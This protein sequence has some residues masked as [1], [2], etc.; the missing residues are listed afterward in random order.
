MNVQMKRYDILSEFGAVYDFLDRQYDPVHL[1]GYLLPEFWE[2]AHYHNYFDYHHS[3]RMGI[4]R[5]E[6]EIV[7]LSVYEMELGHA[8]I[9][10]AAGYEWLWPELL[11]WAEREIS[12]STDDDD[13]KKKL[14]VWTTNMEITKR[15]FLES[16]GYGCVYREPVKIYRYPPELPQ[17]LLP[18]GFHLITGDQVDRVKLSE[19]YWRGFNHE[20]PLP[21][22]E[23]DSSA[24]YLTAPHAR[25]EL[26]TVVVAP[27]GE[28]AAALG[29]W[30]NQEHHY[31]YLEPLAT[32][33]EYR[34]KG[35]AAAALM[36]AM[37]RTQPLGATE[38]F[39]GGN[40]FYTRLGFEHTCDRELWERIWVA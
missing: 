40:E 4:W 39:G 2:Y 6:T 24:K 27:N 21:A 22:K 5:D 28:Y 15:K 38:C 29:M 9:S 3:H 13:G 32:V 36:D 19:C 16:R 30:V 25:N 14:Q 20:G 26:T 18:A 31:A 37:L 1:N 34:Q 11:D 23:A 17:R 12:V 33:P 10:A 7:G 8:F 35:L